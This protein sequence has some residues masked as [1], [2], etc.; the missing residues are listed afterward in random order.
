MINDLSPLDGAPGVHTH[1]AMSVVGLNRDASATSAPVASGRPVLTFA[2]PDEDRAWIVKDPCGPGPH[3]LDEITTTLRYIRLIAQSPNKHAACKRLAAELARECGVALSER[4]SVPPRGWSW[5]SLYRKY[6]EYTGGCVRKVQR[7]GSTRDVEFSAGDWRI[8]WDKAK[9]PPTGSASP[10]VSAVPPLFVH[11]VRTHA[12]NNQRGSERAYDEIIRHVWRTGYALSDIELPTGLAGRGR[13]IK[14]GHRVPFMPGYP[15]WQPGMELPEG[16]SMANLRRQINKLTGRMDAM[17]KKAARIGKQAA[18]AHRRKVNLSRVGLAI[19]E[20]IPCDDHDFNVKIINVH[21]DTFM[22]PSGFFAM[23]LLSYHVFTHGIKPTLWDFDAE[24]K[25]V[26]TEA[27]AKW[28]LIHIL[29]NFGRRTDERGTT[30]LLEHAKMTVRD[31]AEN[32]QF[33]EGL[34]ALGVTIEK[35]GREDRP[36]HMGQLAPAM[37][38]KGRG[39]FRFKPI[40]GWF[41]LLDNGCAFMAGQTGKDRNHSPEQLPMIE[42]ECRAL[43]R[44][45]QHL[46]AEARDQIEWPMLRWPDFFWQVQRVIHFLETRTD[47]NIE[48][49]EQCGFIT[50]ALTDPHGRIITPAR[51]QSPMEVFHQRRHELKKLQRWEWPGLMGPQHCYRAAGEDTVLVTKDSDIVIQAK[52]FTGFTAALRF[53]AVDYEGR[54]LP[55]GSRWRAFVNPYDLD[56]LVLTDERNKPIAECPR[57]ATPSRNDVEGVRREMGRVAQWEA[58]A[59]EPFNARH[60]AAGAAIAAR[61]EHNAN[62][63]SGRDYRAEELE[64]DRQERASSRRI[65]AEPDDITTAFSDPV[66]PNETRSEAQQQA[67]ALDEFGD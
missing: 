47:H 56:C 63:I 51:L 42:R 59:L 49:W 61:R 30:F 6:C 32:Q 2:V 20:F 67:D 12:E 31:T 27:D 10:S 33:L 21:Q 53:E 18:A 34:T 23:D 55:I 41:N 5:K 38:G 58:A 9:Y 8:V 40:E 66:P 46:P 60:T 19:G 37:P 11:F 26:L 24:Q 4:S 29:T 1:T 44:A 62:V 45:A 52:P 57:M 39:N 35:S 7:N 13:V 54:R 16:L 14:R 22:R 17:A 64:A 50:D 43:L 3:A 36:A 48:G 15:N 25:R 28:F 65:A